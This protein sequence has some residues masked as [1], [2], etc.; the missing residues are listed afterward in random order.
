[1]QNRRSSPAS[2]PKR[3]KTA[4]SRNVDTTDGYLRAVGKTLGEWES[5]SDEAAHREFEDTPRS[6][7][8]SCLSREK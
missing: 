3:S 6:R 1:M 4:A 8:G 5:H 2:R 7:R